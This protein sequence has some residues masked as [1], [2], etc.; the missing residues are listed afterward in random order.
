[1]LAALGEL[2]G[3]R[4]E[5]AAD[6]AR[7]AADRPLGDRHVGEPVDVQ[8]Q[9]AAVV[10]GIGTVERADQR[11]SGEVDSLRTQTGVAHG[12]EQALDHVALGGDEHD[13]LAG[14]LG[15]VDDAERVEVEDGVAERHRHL[16]LGLEAHGGGELLAIG[17]RRQ[18]ERAQ[19]RALVGDADAHALAQPAVA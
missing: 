13:L 4:L 5:A 15:R 18:L 12:R 10:L 1:M 8:V 6:D 3:H 9:D 16:L 14:S 11:E 2:A 7:E 19:H 17:D